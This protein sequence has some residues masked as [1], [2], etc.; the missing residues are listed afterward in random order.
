MKT[1]D[2]LDALGALAQESRL[3]VFRYLVE[4]GPEGSPVGKIADALNLPAATLSFHLKELSRA[5]LLVSRQEGRF[6]WYAAN[7]QT[8]NALIAY[9]TEN[10]CGGRPEECAPQ[11]SPKPQ[12][13]RRRKT[14]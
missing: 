5:K 7:F 11:C 13:N 2:A 6:I 14:A 3:A 10:C 1:N 9:L 4:A 8:M 12:T